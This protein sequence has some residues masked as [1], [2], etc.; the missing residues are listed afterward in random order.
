MPFTPVGELVRETLRERGTSG[1]VEP[2]T[3]NHRDLVNRVAGAFAVS[4]DAAKFRL[5]KLGYVRSSA[6]EQVLSG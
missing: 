5:L 4:A 6:R 3:D 1:L 2:G